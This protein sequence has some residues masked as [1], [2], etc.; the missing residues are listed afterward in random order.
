MSTRIAVNGFKN[1]ARNVAKFNEIKQTSTKQHL[2]AFRCVF[3]LNSTESGNHL[4][5]MLFLYILKL[6]R[7]MNIKLNKQVKESGQWQSYPSEIC[8]DRKPS[9]CKSKISV[10]ERKRR[11]FEERERSNSGQRLFYITE[12]Y[13]MKEI[14]VKKT[15][16][17]LQH[18][19][20]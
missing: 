19:P 15:T 20:P 4:K 11:C 2:F 9:M 14:N 16:T 12:F 3:M 6:K 8:Q 17:D 13:K 1:N 5:T 7:R 10:I 18:V